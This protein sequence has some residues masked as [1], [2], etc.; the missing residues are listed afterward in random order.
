MCQ[1]VFSPTEC[2][3]F[4]PQRE[5]L[6]QA[7]ARHCRQ[8]GNWRLV[9]LALGDSEQSHPLHLTQNRAAASILTPLTAGDLTAQTRVIAQETVRLMP[10]DAVVEKEKLPAPDLIK[11]DVQGFESKVL[12]G[13]AAT[14]RKT[15][16]IVIETSLRPIYEGQSLLPDILRTLTS[17]GFHLD[18]MSEVC[19]TWPAGRLWQADLWLRRVEPPT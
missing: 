17:E 15:Q 18:D 10:L 19:R 2:V 9:Q 14:L 11:I 8:G 4:E 7:R 16:R 3:L 13:G 12:T 6:E 5:Y 1:A